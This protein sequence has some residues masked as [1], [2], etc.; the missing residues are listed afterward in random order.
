MAFHVATTKSRCPRQDS[1]SRQHPFTLT[2]MALLTE[3]VAVEPKGRV[4]KVFRAI[5]AIVQ[6]KYPDAGVNDTSMQEWARFRSYLYR[7]YK[8][9]SIHQVQSVLDYLDEL[10]PNDPELHVSILQASP[11][12]IGRPV[13]S[14]LRPTVTFLRGLYGNDLFYK[15]IRRNQDLLL[16]HGVGYKAETSSAESIQSFLQEQMGFSATAITK[17]KRKEPLIFQRPLYTLNS[18]VAFLDDLLQHGNYTDYEIRNTTAKLITKHP[19]MFALSVPFKLQPQLE[20]LEAHC[21]LQPSDIAKAIVTKSGAANLLILSIEENLKPS[22]EYLSKVVARGSDGNGDLKHCLST[23]PGTLNL[24][25]PNI[26]S[27]VEFFDSIDPPRI[28]HDGSRIPSQGL[29]ARVLLRAPAVYSMSLSDNLIPKIKFLAGVWGMKVYD[30]ASCALETDDPDRSFALLLGES[31]TILSLSLECNIQPTYKFYNSTGYIELDDN[32]KL[33]P[34]AESVR[35]I[36]GR[37][38]GVSLFNRLLPRW[39]FVRSKQVSDQMPSP[40]IP[41]DIL[42]GA[43]DAAFCSIYNATDEEYDEFKAEAIPRLK[44]SSQFDTWLKTGRPIELE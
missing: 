38:I 16:T 7:T 18:V 10:F 36:R 13:D 1:N 39:H 11:R 20:F 19:R 14:F 30:A 22:I 33:K 6:D 34:K 37:E 26:K 43:T 41:L 42:V 5:T 44:F 4:N 3:E 23:Y 2:F 8:R 31:P 12:I 40:L 32:W 29:A 21:N 27:K 25:L 35:L 17:L 24:A 15:A 9:L 28:N